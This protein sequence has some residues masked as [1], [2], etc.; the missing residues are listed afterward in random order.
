LGQ[1]TGELIERTVKI[2][3]VIAWRLAALT[4]LGRETPES[5]AKVCFT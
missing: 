4:L 5:P 1:R 3:A 2:K